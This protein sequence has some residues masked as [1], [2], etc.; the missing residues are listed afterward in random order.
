MKLAIVGKG[1][2]GGAVD[3]GFDKD[4]T[5]FIVDPKLGTSIDELVSFEPDVTFVCVPTPMGQNGAIDSSIVESSIEYLKANVTGLIVLKSTVVPD[6]VK[7]LISGPNGYRVIYNPEFLT[8]KA[9]NEDF[10]NPQLHVFG[11]LEK[12][13]QQLEDIY[14]NHSRCKPCPVFH[15]KAVEASFVKYGINS[16]LATKVLWFNQFYDSVEGFG[17]NYNVVVNALTSDPRVGGSHT[18]VPGFDGRRGYGGACFTK[19]VGALLNFDPS[20]T[21][22]R[23]VQTVN[24]AYR[25]VYE[26]DDREKEQNVVYLKGE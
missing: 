11:G 20:L 21:V 18:I 1:F 26:L 23:E 15:M 13:T 19:D 2:V 24:N 16:F 8:E 6:V 3:F 7:K 25:S 12:Q 17:A 10:V 5:K 14:K 22:L 9:A 4:V